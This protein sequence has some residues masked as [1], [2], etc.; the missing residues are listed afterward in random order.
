VIPS[1]RGKRILH[2]PR[3][4]LFFEAWRLLPQIGAYRRGLSRT[5]R[6]GGSLL[7]SLIDQTG[8]DGVPPSGTTCHHQLTEDYHLGFIFIA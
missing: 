1:A 3:T 5:F 4:K 8:P 2:S 7:S 6:G